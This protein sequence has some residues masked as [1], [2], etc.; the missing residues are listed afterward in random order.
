MSALWSNKHKIQGLTDTRILLTKGIK[1][2]NVLL[3]QRAECQRHLT[4]RTPIRVEKGKGDDTAHNEDPNLDSCPGAADNI[5]ALTGDL[6]VDPKPVTGC[7]NEG[8]PEDGSVQVVEVSDDVETSEGTI[9]VD[10]R[11]MIPAIRTY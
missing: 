11:F 3:P 9:S 4:R 7:R 2:L 6:L 5:L 8:R 10:D 1:S